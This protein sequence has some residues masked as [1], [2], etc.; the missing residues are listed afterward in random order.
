MENKYYTPKI[1]EFHIGFEIQLQNIENVQW[2]NY[3]IMVSD[4][5]TSLYNENIDWI[6]VKY[7]NREDIEYLGWKFIEAH[8]QFPSDYFKP[9]MKFN[10]NYSDNN[11][12][13]LEILT[14]YTRHTIC[15]KFKGAFGKVLF[16]GFCKNKSELSRLMVQIGIAK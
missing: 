13:E 9:N 4:N 8:K 16:E 6:R 15:V 14:D 11:L 3:T 10:N 12:D 1:E 2:G 5:I 7:L